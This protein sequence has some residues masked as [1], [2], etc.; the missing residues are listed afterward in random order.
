M[1]DFI[2]LL[3]RGKT[4][5]HVVN[6]CKSILSENGFV[7]LCMDGEFNLEDGGRYMLSPYSSMLVAF[8]YNKESVNTRLAVAHTDFPM[9]KLKPNPI[10]R[11]NGYLQVNVE[12]YGGLITASWFDRPLGLAGKLVLQGENVFSPEVRLFD[13]DKPVF[14][15]PN[16][17]P[18][19]ARDKKNSETDMQKE[20]IPIAGLLSSFPD[21]DSSNPLLSYIA[22]KENI[23]PETIL[24]Y[25][26]YLYVYGAPTFVGLEDD[27]LTAP[28]IDNI[29]SVSALCRA[30]CSCKKPT[31][32][33]VTAFFDNEE[34]GS[35]S[36]QGADSI[37][38]KDIMEKIHGRKPDI[39]NMFTLSV[40][41]A[42]A[43]HPNYTEKSDV[44]NNVIL[45]DGIVL[46][47]SA[48]QRYVTDSEAGAVVSALCQS[49]HIKLQ[50]QANR[51]G[52]AGGQTLGPILSSYLPAKAADIGIP[53]LAM[54]SAGELIHK[55]D[56]LALIKLI[57]AYFTN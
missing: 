27:F 5:F 31:C 17:A 21:E 19:L 33:A 15:I 57:E 29:S 55:N 46:K 4:Q 2:N 13:S 51:S 1:N 3:E 10:I 34:I 25:D 48:S 7:N 39:S 30:I 44:T 8:I 50:R 47:S 20:L 54:H 22:A 35:R 14:I 45:G 12:P 11:K 32:T 16:L 53:M 41:V 26:L 38:L 40:D 36:K 6:Q 9:L 18:H 52:M 56:Y 37:L 43:T 42:H 23:D 28:R 24:D 49:N